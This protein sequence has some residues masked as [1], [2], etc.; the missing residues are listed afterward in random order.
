VGWLQEHVS[1]LASDTSELL[2]ERIDFDPA[3]VLANDDYCRAGY[4]VLTDAEREAVGLFARQ[5]G[6][7]LDPVYTGRAAAGM[8]DLIQKGF[9]KKSETVLFWHTG[10]QPALFAEQYASS[11]L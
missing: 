4:G 6:L 7:L 11:I 9:F 2:G 8:I 1:E 10:G 5:E 3:E